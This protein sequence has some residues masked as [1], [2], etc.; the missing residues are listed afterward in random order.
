MYK[1][2]FYTICDPTYIGSSVGQCM[3]SCIYEK[4]IIEIWY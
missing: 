3:P 4:P 2:K 1:D